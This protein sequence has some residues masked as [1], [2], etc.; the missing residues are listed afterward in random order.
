MAL[1]GY[2][3]VEAA[4]VNKLMLAVLPCQE[5]KA[6]KIQTPEIDINIS[7]EHKLD[8]GDVQK[9]HDLY[10]GIQDK[11]VPVSAITKS[12]ELIK[13]EELTLNHFLLKNHE[14]PSYGCSIMS[15]WKC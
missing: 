5:E 2:V 1:R 12:K 3:L 4:L 15:M 13:F 6:V 9:I 8:A 10:E 14:Q 11:S 7:S